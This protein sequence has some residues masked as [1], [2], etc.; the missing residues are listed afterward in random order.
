M[1]SDEC[2]NYEITPNSKGKIDLWLKKFPPHERQSGLIYALLQVQDDNG[3][4]LNNAQIEA[5]ATYLKVPKIAAYE[6]ATFYTMFDLKPC[7][8]YKISICTNVSCLLNDSE[9]VVKFL[10]QKLDIGFNET[11]L[12]GRF[13]LK[14]VECLAAC[15]GA[16]VVQIDKTYHEKV[17]PK[18]MAEILGELT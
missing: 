5:V 15:S 11:T 3:G 7:G 1:K 18:R 10:K 17:T 9:K 2:V 6:V 14:E 16:P 8:Q 12:D 13:T 4:W